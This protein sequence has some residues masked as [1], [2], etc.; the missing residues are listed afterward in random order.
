MYETNFSSPVE[1]PR[2]RRL[3]E[4]LLLTPPHARRHDGPRRQ[5][6]YVGERVSF[7]KS[8][9]VRSQDDH[10]SLA[11]T[12]EAWSPRRQAF[13]V[14]F[15]DPFEEAHTET[16][17]HQGSRTDESHDEDQHMMIDSGEDEDED[18]PVVLKGLSVAIVGDGHSYIT[19]DE[20]GDGW[21]GTSTV[22]YG[23][24]QHKACFWFGAW[25]DEATYLGPQRQVLP[26]EPLF[27]LCRRVEKA[28]PP[29]PLVNDDKVEDSDLIE[30]TRCND[31]F[32]K[33]CVV[34]CKKHEDIDLEEE[35]WNCPLCD[36]T[37]ITPKVQ[38]MPSDMNESSLFSNI[39]R[40]LATRVDMWHSLSKHQT[41][42]GNPNLEWQ[43]WWHIDE[44]RR[45][46]LGKRRKRTGEWVFCL[47]TLRRHVGM[48]EIHDVGEPVLELK[49][50]HHLLSKSYPKVESEAEESMIWFE[51]VERQRREDEEDDIGHLE[52]EQEE[53][54]ILEPAPRTN[55]PPTS[56][57]QMSCDSHAP[58]KVREHQNAQYGH[59]SQSCS[60]TRPYDKHLALMKASTSKKQRGPKRSKRQTA[61]ATVH[62]HHDDT[63]VRTQRANSRRVNTSV[64]GDTLGR[65]RQ[66]RFGRSPIHMWG[67]F[68]DEPITCGEF[69]AE[70]KGELVSQQEADRRFAYYMSK[71]MSDYLFSIDSN[72]ICDATVKGSIARFINHSCEPNCEARIVMHQNQKKIALYALR[73]LEVGEELCYDYK[74]PIEEGSDA[75]IACNC[76]AKKCRKVMN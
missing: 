27:C 9:I 48:K 31:W 11:G 60:R 66:L 49:A 12:C 13:L 21:G 64:V 68:A 30:C 3:Q 20:G 73:D 61:S 44:S 56:H 14:V 65:R 45:K 28:E 19:Y 43:F 15:D 25:L 26:D 38:R 62:Q 35:A 67:V 23:A 34:A 1:S 50:M 7:P 2:R 17:S 59:T 54:M 75:K 58:F 10:E 24:S 53:E 8:L 39:D 16:Q 51:I 70:Y 37:V 46:K 5:E 4:Q 22:R 29:P 42:W 18:V 33:E 32:H 72:I 57:P 74:F 6:F 69:V 52:T 55:L 76:G 63:S 36:G 71:G 41:I 40:D 47:A